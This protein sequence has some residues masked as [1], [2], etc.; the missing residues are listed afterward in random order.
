MKA[1][2]AV[3]SHPM[4]AVARRGA[5]RS[6]VFSAV[7][8]AGLIGLAVIVGIVLLQ[9]IDD[10]S[11]GPANGGGGGGGT[12]TDTTGDTTVTTAGPGRPVAEVTVVVLNAG[13]PSGAAGNVTNTLRL[14]GYNTLAAGNDPVARQGVAVQCRDGFDAEAATLAGHVQQNATVEPFP[15]QPPAEAADADCIV[16]LGTPT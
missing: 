8:G 16:L 12:T 11:S 9:V 10:G 5:A 7:R 3:S 6:L 15:A 14:V 1:A 2:V 13:Q 4:V